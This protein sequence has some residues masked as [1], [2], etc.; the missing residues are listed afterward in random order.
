MGSGEVA[1]SRTGKFVALVVGLLALVGMQGYFLWQELRPRPAAPP[2][3][4]VPRPLP[5][6]DAA[7][8]DYDVKEYMS[9]LLEMERTAPSLTPQQAEAILELFGGTHHDL[10]ESRQLYAQAA[11][12]LTEEQREFLELEQDFYK[13]PS[14]AE[15][16][17]FYERLKE[18][19]GVTE[20]PPLD[21][22]A[23]LVRV[24]KSVPYLDLLQA[25]FDEVQGQERVALDREQMRQLLPYYRYFVDEEICPSTD[26][27]LAEIL[28]EPQRHALA[29]IMAHLPFER[30]NT[31]VEPQ[32]REHLRK[33][34]AG[35][36]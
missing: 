30:R 35:T 14:A 27:C 7:P 26:T 8:D 20:V 21:P 13:P 6:G 1:S 23:G 18:A 10:R 25:H 4:P 16:K 34:A 11:E 17:A 24:R 5:F 2:P 28:T 19:A 33:T 12:H 36:R 32:L 9:G 29:G 22:S 15:R 31:D 3:P